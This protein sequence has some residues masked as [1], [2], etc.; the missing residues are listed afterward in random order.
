MELLEAAKWAG[1]VGEGGA[2]FPTCAKL[3]TK[4]ECFIVNGAECEPLIE[5][6]KYLMRTFPDEIVAG[7]AAVSA[8]LG[9]RRA[10]IALKT[11]YE[12]EAAALAAAIEKSGAAIEIV[13][14]PSFYPAGDEHTLVYY[15]TG[16]SIPA[17]GIPISVG[18]VVDNVGTMRS[19]HKALAGRPV[20]DKYLSVTGEVREPVMLRVP[21]GTSFRECVTLAGARLS[22]YAV[23]NGGPMMGLVLSEPEKI[24]A[25][26]VTKTTGNILVLPPDHYLVERSKLKMQRIRLQS[27]SACIQCRYCTDLCPR[28]LIGQEMEPHMV[29]RGLWME[30]RIKDDEEFVRAFGDAMNCCSC[31]I[32]E[33]YACPMNLSPRRVNEYFKGVL[34]SRGLESKVDPHPAAR[35][36][37]A[38]RLIPTERIVARL[39]L[40]DYYPGHAARCLEYT[41]KEVYIPFRQSIGRAAEAVVEEG[42]RVNRGDLIARAAEGLSSNIYASIDGIVKDLSVQGA[43]IASGG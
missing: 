3:G 36:S 17:R 31:G 6:D 30:G 18:C 26:V 34:R 39:G 10:V 33:L 2:G 27:R 37:F 24:D 7:T 32:C 42:A 25:A 1:V 20:L 35:D 13:K 21:I 14:M 8:H 19:V 22:A 38:D 43:R 29:M 16:R 9:A 4:A 5:T 11:K 15:V 28:W 41:P 40:R 23:V 12:A